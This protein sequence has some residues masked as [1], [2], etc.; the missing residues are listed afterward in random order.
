MVFE[1][2]RAGQP[3]QV[4]FYVLIMF[5]IFKVDVLLMFCH[6][7]LRIRLYVL[8]GRDWAPYIPHVF[9]WDWNPQSYSIGRGLD[10]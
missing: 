10:S 1:V 4:V 2:L 7:F 6:N 8:F 3:L 5:K 9:G